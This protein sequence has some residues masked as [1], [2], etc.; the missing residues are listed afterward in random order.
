MGQAVATASQA[1]IPAWVNRV[2]NEIP[3]TSESA[4]FLTGGI[5]PSPTPVIEK[6]KELLDLQN[7][8][9]GDPRINPRIAVVEEEC[10]VLAA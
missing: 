8:G 9:P 6:V 7:L 3:T 10:R 4:Y 5:G 1:T 2:R